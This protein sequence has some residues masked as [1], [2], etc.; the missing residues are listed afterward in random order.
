MSALLYLGHASVFAN[1]S[2]ALIMRC[3]HRPHP[4]ISRGKAD[5]F[6]LDVNSLEQVAEATAALGCRPLAERVAT[7]LGDFKS[8]VRMHA[9]VLTHTSRGLRAVRTGGTGQLLRHGTYTVRISASG[10]PYVP[11]TVD[12][13]ARVGGRGAPERRGRL[14]GCHGRH[15]VRPRS[16]AAR[17]PW[18]CYHHPSAGAVLCSAVQ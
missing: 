10:V 2:S 13:Q 17:T 7:L 18:R 6:A 16:L 8:R 3:G 15:G 1:Y 5:T 12:P 11:R 4:C 14:L 9:S